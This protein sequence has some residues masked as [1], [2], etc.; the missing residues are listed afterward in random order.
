MDSVMESPRRDR[1]AY[2]VGRWC[3]EAQSKA[4]RANAACKSMETA[5]HPGKHHDRC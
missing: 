4:L 2:E 1:C 5:R 3:V